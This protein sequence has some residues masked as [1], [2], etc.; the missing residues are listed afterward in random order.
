[1]MISFRRKYFGAPASAPG[2]KPPKKSRVRSTPLDNG[3]AT[4]WM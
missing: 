2:A 4:V 3:G 1:M